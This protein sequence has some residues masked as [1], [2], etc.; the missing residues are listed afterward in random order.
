MV[1]WW[2]LSN[3]FFGWKHE[4]KE[5]LFVVCETGL[6][7]DIS[8]WDKLGPLFNLFAEVLCIILFQPSKGLLFVEDE[9][10]LTF[11]SRLVK[12]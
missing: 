6:R 11:F 4:K 12:H 10:V 2:L 1:V 8:D 3:R 7:M 5:W 9:F